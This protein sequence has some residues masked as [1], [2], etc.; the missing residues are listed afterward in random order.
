MKSVLRVSGLQLDLA[1]EQ[2]ELNIASIDR[3]MEDCPEDSDVIVLPE[4]WSTGFTMD[5]AQHA[6]AAESGPGFSAMQ[7]WARASRAMVC[8][9]L[10]VRTS[11][12]FRNRHY[13]VQPDGSF[14][15][16]DKRHAFRFA[17]EHKHYQPGTD[18]V[19]VDCK[20]W[21][22]L[23]L[24]CYDL[25]FPVFSRNTREQRYHGIL[26][27]ANWPAARIAAW[28]TLLQARAIENQAYVVG[29][30]RTGLDG[31]GIEHTGQSAFISPVGVPENFKDQGWSRCDW[32]A[33]QLQDLRAKFPVL[34]D[35]DRFQLSY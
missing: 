17:G 33:E 29:V 25:R 10:S 23:L 30:N 34:E 27:V 11:S 12:G 28:S 19:I 31:N 8:G 21:K 2:P 7:R 14:I 5:P 24:T 26:Y 35:A 32:S 15:H 4:M 18:R 9:S 6:E 20:G 1:W 22:L 3:W 16:Y 13:A